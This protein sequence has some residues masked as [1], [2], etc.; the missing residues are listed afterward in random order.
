MK[1]FKEIKIPLE[2]EKLKEIHKNAKKNAF[3]FF[4]E[5]GFSE[6]EGKYM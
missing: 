6:S 3:N 2:N 1:F 4:S 5:K